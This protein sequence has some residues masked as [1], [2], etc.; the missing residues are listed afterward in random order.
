MYMPLL[1]MRF[2]LAW[3]TMT[4]ANSSVLDAL[5]RMSEY[6]V[7]SIPVIDGTNHLMGNISMADVRVRSCLQ[8]MPF[9]VL[10]L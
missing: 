8:V 4:V 7:S 5:E 6:G 1:L 2:Y 3:L 9:T 10:C